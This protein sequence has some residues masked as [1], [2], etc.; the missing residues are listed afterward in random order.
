[1][2]IGQI[3]LLILGFAIDTIISIAAGVLLWISTIGKKKLTRPWGIVM[4]V[5]YA[6]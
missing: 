1:M 3:L 4:L 2:I 6:A 5:C